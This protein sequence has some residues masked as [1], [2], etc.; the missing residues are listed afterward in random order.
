MELNKYYETDFCQCYKI[1]KPSKEIM[2]FFNKHYYLIIYYT[3]FDCNHEF[4]NDLYSLFMHD[5][6]F[7]FM[8]GFNI[9]P[10]NRILPKS[11]D[12]FK[13]MVSER[14]TPTNRYFELLKD[15]MLYIIP[16]SKTNKKSSFQILD[17]QLLRIPESIKSLNIILNKYN[18]INEK[19]PIK[20]IEILKGL[21]NGFGIDDN[22]SMIK[23]KDSYK[24]GVYQPL[25]KNEIIFGYN[26]KSS[27]IKDEIDKISKIENIF[28]SQNQIIELYPTINHSLNEL[29][30]IKGAKKSKNN[31]SILI[32]YSDLLKSNI[33]WKITDFLC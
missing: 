21:I 8:F 4:T 14:S 24:E 29:L 10:M 3:P 1:N 17:K 2:S 33:K 18:E 5:F 31:N 9:V 7:F 11:K 6:D 30:K 25:K 19:N 15:E 16:L 13:H 22:Y 27:S 26:F 20:I 32:K 28:E 12:S 23:F